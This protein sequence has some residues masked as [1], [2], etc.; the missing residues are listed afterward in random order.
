MNEWNARVWRS[1]LKK[2]KSTQERA[3]GGD[4]KTRKRKGKSRNMHAMRKTRDSLE[5]DDPNDEMRERSCKLY[6]G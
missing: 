4:V 3:S 5:Q 6:D 2:E 1:E